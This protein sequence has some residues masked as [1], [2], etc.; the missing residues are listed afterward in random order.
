MSYE[1]KLNKSM[2]SDIVVFSYTD[3]ANLKNSLDYFGKFHFQS[4]TKH[5]ND[6]SKIKSKVGDL[7]AAYLDDSEYNESLEKAIKNMDNEDNNMRI[8]TE[9]MLVR[10]VAIFESFIKELSLIIQKIEKERIAPY[11]KDKHIELNDVLDYIKTL[12]G[13]DMKGRKFYAFYKVLKKIRNKIAHGE[14]IINLE[15]KE[16]CKLD[17]YLPHK[18]ILPI[19]QKTM[20]NLGEKVFNNY[21]SH[22]VSVQYDINRIFIEEITNIYKLMHKKYEKEA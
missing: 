15:D 17:E 6:L 13:I 4:K 22:G 8:F 11:K 7:A 12:T 14:H 10:H 9:S 18:L 19:E 1:D 20:L 2:L 21:I 5:L 3:L 16:L